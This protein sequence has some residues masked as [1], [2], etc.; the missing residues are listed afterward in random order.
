[1]G[2][3]V[4]FDLAN[5]RVILGTMIG[6]P[7]SRRRLSH[8]LRPEDF[9]DP[10]HQVAFRGLTKLAKAGLAWSEDTFAELVRGE[11]FGGWS[12]IRQVQ[13]DFDPNKNLDFH[14]GR[15]R[16]DSLKFAVLKDDLPNLSGLCE[17]PQ[18]GTDRLLAASRALM[19][20]VERHGERFVLGGDSLVDGYYSTLRLRGAVGGLVEGTGFPLMDRALAVGFAPGTL[21]VAVA[22]PGHGKT[23]WLANLIRHRVAAERGTFVCGWEMDADDYLDMMVAAETGIPAIDLV[24]RVRELDA[25]TKKI[26][27]EAVERYR[28]RDLLEIEENPFPRLERPKDRWFDLNARN[29]DHFEATV[30]R[31][32]ESKS[33]FALDVVGKMFANR[34]PDKIGE[35]LVRIRGMAKAYGVHILLLHHLNRSGAEGRP[36]LETI[37]NSGAF[38]EEADLIFGLDRPILRASAARRRKTEDV[39]DVHILKQRKGPA[40]VCVRYRFDGSRYALGG[41]VEVDLSMLDR[42]E[43][44]EGG[45]SY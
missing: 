37:K 41:E 28:R 38:E 16:L 29:L 17:D 42:E 35:A 34:D 7:E 36:T 44:G 18:A 20:R 14:I 5:E 30:S 19:G 22:R 4:E 3:V 24:R 1:M 33:F 13:K 21:S 15:L 45:G 39:L 43:N 31:A 10:R 2:R 27:E 8:D 40:P 6:S 11:D 12:Y 23:T 26:I 25:R 9:G 32:S